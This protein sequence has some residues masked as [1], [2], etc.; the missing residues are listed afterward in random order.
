MPE[1]FQKTLAVLGEHCG[2]QNSPYIDLAD[3]IRKH[4]F[5]GKISL[6]SIIKLIINDFDTIAE[7]NTFVRV[8]DSYEAEEGNNDDLVMG[9]VL[10][11]WLTAQT[12]FKDSTNIDVRQLMLAEQNMF[13]EED[14]TPVGIIDDGRQ[15]EV[16]VDAGDVWT[17]KGY[18]S[19]RF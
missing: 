18:L 10:F 5:T 11:A 14:L 7:L 13:I 6:L 19:S 1:G 9:L 8:R 2:I 16:L 15:E 3:D 12:Y 17:E 4:V